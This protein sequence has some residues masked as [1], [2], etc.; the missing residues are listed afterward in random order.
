MKTILQFSFLLLISSFFNCNRNTK[1]IAIQPDH[2]SIESLTAVN[3]SEDM[4]EVS[5][6]EDEILL[7]ILLV[8]KQEAQFQVLFEWTH[9]YTFRNRNEVSPIS[10]NIPIT[11]STNKGEQLLFFLTELDNEHSEQSVINALKEAVLQTNDFSLLD[12]ATIDRSLGHDDLLGFHA[13]NLNTLHSKSS[14]SIQF[15]G[16]QLFDRFEYLLKI[17]F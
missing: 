6:K 10:K 12:K 8:K 11:S 3:L 7:L 17:G 1:P 5:T 13:L 9:E 15:K 14:N 4:N 16:L 2:I